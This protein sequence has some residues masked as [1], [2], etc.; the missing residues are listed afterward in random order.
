MEFFQGM[1]FAVPVSVLMWVIIIAVCL[2]W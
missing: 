2:R 1:F